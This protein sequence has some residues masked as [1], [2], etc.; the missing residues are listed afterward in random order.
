MIVVDPLV[1]RIAY[2]VSSLTLLEL[3][4]VAR[5]VQ[6]KPEEVTLCTVSPEF[7][8]T[9]KYSTSLAFLVGRVNVIVFWLLVPEVEWSNASV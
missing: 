6:V 7:S 9:D 2:H 4:A 1:D 3:V 5:L 8:T